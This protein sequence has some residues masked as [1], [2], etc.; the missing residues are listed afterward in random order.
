MNLQGKRIVITRS[1]DQ[2]LETVELVKKAGGVPVLF[3]TIEIVAPESWDPVDKAI[4]RLHSYHWVI[5]TSVNGVRF[6][7]SRMKEL[8]VPLEELGRKRL[9]SI[10]PATGKALNNLGLKVDVVPER[11]V[12][13]SVLEALKS[14][15]DLNGLRILLPRAEVARETLPIGLREAGAEVDVVAVY[16]TVRASPSDELKREVLNS[17]V[18]TFTSP[19]TLTNFVEI[20]GEQAEEAFKNKVVACI[21]PVT[22]KR[23]RELGV[24]IHLVAEEYTTE[25]LL[26]AV[27]QAL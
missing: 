13:E 4:A 9:C 6:F 19:S 2:A 17:E 11:F 21:G 5:F 15:G 23:A 7:T 16:R 24:P 12:A 20:M 8:E 27:S 26:K 3:P 1:A 25:G 18:L 10:G 14:Q 22:E